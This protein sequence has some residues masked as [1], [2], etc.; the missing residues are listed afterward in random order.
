MGLPH[1]VVRFYTNRDGRSARRTTVVVL[2]LLSLFYLV[3]TGYGVLGRIYATDLIG[4]GRADSVVLALPERML[5]AGAGDR[6]DRPA[7]GRGV[8]RVPVHLLGTGDLGRRGA[9]PGPAQPAA[10]RGPAF[11]AGSTSRPRW[12]R[13]G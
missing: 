7:G 6:A 11:R 8:R 12:S 1:V 3:P 5:G 2:G 4:A 10:G 9:Q 13:W